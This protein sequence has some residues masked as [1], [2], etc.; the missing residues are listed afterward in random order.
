MSAAGKDNTMKAKSLSVFRTKL[1]RNDPGTVLVA[2]G[3]IIEGDDEHLRALARNRLVVLLDDGAAG[4]AKAAKPKAEAKPKAK[5]K[6]DAK[7]G[8]AAKDVPGKTVSAPLAGTGEGVQLPAP[9]GG[10]DLP[11][12]E[13]TPAGE[14]SE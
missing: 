9:D 6:A 14:G 4:N 5:D 7:P 12:V 11:P 13:T 2:I 10:A 8:P 1:R 3:Q